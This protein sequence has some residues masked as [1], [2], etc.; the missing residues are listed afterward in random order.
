MF[1]KVTWWC[2]N[3]NR[4]HQVTYVTIFYYIKENISLILF[5]RLKLPRD[6]LWLYWCTNTLS[7]VHFKLHSIKQCLCGN[8][9]FPSHNK[10]A[11]YCIFIINFKII[12]LKNIITI[13]SYSIL[14]IRKE[15]TFLHFSLFY[16]YFVS[17]LRPFMT[18]T[19]LIHFFFITYLFNYNNTSTPSS[20]S[21]QTK[22]ESCK[23]VNWCY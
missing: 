21:N 23:F 5:Q 13:L 8:L 20:R 9:F 12:N 14:Y 1:T 11:T 3:K 4:L 7:S 17:H 6:N 22:L 2:V 19:I 18:C 16:L 10:F 15:N